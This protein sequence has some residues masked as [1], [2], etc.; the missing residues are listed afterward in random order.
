MKLSVVRLLGVLAIAHALSHI[1]LPLRGSFQP[2]Y[3]I[4]DYTPI[5]LY[6]VCTSGF[7]IAGI[8]LVGLRLLTPFVSPLLVLSSVLSSVALV[9][10]GDVDLI[11]GALL[12]AAFFGIGVWSAFAGWPQKDAVEID[13]YFEHL[14]PKTTR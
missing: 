6:I 7:L 1:I 13:D 5:L 9:R 11:F 4:R 3:L 2:A 14:A 12:N 10:L 8:G